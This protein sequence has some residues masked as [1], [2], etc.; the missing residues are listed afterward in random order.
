M[1]APNTEPNKPTIGAGL[2][3]S[4]VGMLVVFLEAFAL[5]S[6]RQGDTLSEVIRNAVR[7]DSLGR[8]V[9]LPLWC[10][11]TWHWMLR[12]RGNMG[13]GWQ[14][15]AALGVGVL[16]AVCEAVGLLSWWR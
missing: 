16:W 6:P 7:F 3:W 4:C 15:C 10:W 14:D 2:L 1:T 13:E 11:L 5:G 8:F 12:P 9:L